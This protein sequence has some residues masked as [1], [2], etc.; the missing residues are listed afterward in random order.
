MTG[1]GVR[2]MTARYD[3]YCAV[4]GCGATIRKGHLLYRVHDTH[5]LCY[6]CGRRYVDALPR[7]PD[8]P[9]PTAN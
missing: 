3:G 6:E 7:T 1:T 8:K 2:A 5:T 9:R 4:A